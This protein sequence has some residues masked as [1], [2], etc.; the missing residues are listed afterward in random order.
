MISE[1]SSPDPP[2]LLIYLEE[3]LLCRNLQKSLISCALL[4]FSS[5]SL[6]GESMNHSMPLITLEHDL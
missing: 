1:L 6:Q 2:R 5:A 4:H 3:V